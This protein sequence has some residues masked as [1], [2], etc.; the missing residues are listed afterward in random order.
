MRP[1]VKKEKAATIKARV[2]IKHMDNPWYQ[3]A[4]IVERKAK[5]V[6]N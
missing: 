1:W 6:C 2:K 4:V 5:Y 3:Y